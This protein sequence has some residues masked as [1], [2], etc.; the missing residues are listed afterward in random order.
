MRSPKRHGRKRRNAKAGGGKA[1][2][3]DPAGGREID[4][5]IEAIGHSGDGIGRFEGVPVFVP[6]ALPGD[7]LIVR[8]DARR[9][10]GFAASMRE[11]ITAAPRSIPPCSHF[12]R[13]GGCQLQHLF[14]DDYQRWQIHQVKKA[15]SS[16]GL[17]G[18]EIRPV[19]EGRP[20]T[21]RR[22]RL[23]FDRGQRER[24]GCRIEPDGGTVDL[25]FRER[26][27]RTVVSISACPIA[28]PS[29]TALLPSL[30]AL[31]GRLAMAK[32]GG[33]IL[34]TA[35]DTG[36]DLLLQTPS[37]P[38][39]ADRERLGAFAESADLARLAWR[40]DA[41]ETGEPIAARRPVRIDMGGIAVDLPIGAFL[42]ATRHAETAIRESITEAIRD[43]EHIVDLFAG[44]GAF[45]LPFAA[46]GRKASAF[47]RD[48][49]MID[50]LTGAAKSAP[51]DRC[52][53]AAVRDLDRAP[54]RRDELTAIDVV[55]LDPPRVG[56]RTQVEQLAA[57]EVKN[58]AMVSCNPATFARDAHLLIDGG[59][60]LLW[61][62][63][64][65]AFLWSAQIELV[66]AFAR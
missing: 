66:G 11:V 24:P 64:I 31:L 22:L 59:Y 63:P 36:I 15:L 7:H 35:A 25:G 60:R 55:I 43:G 26:Y 34:L 16:R 6:F 28:L 9:Q 20:A 3:Q 57:S 54:L 17:T 53:Q 65:D 10:G 18:I 12:E 51:I 8:L 49:A 48:P 13:C 58:I 19:I 61:V 29:L 5:R 30:K 62:Q 1:R 44:C 33:E 23:A 37:S 39:L 21:R 41:H 40:P 32:E 56:A 38:D 50:A 47:E 52:L 42:Q 2:P 45:S 46:S 14:P 27:G 4:L